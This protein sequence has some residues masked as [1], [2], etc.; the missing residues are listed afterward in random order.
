MQGAP[1]T[2]ATSPTESKPSA[3]GCVLMASGQAKR[4]GSNKLLADFGGKPLLTRAFA[5][6]EGIFTA[7]VTVT[8]SIEVQALCEECGIP[9]L[10]HALPFRSDTVRLGLEAL[11][12]QFPALSGCLFLPGDQPLLTRQ[13]LAAMVQAFCAAPHP[14][15][16]IFRLCDPQTGTPGSP[17]LFGADYFDEL[18]SLPEGKGGGVVVKQHA[19]QV[20]L[21]PSR[22]PA[23]LMDADTPEMLEKLRTIFF[24]DKFYSST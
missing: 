10:H 3:V 6:T 2:T 12:T 14:E 17:V 5:A 9:V 23:E 8:R 4:F 1:S 7:R 18:R 13:T 20:A 22:H 24:T 19:E 21:F 16:C 15:Q 11:Q